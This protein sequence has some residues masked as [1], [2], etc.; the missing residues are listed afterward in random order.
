[1]P[2]MG[3]YVP[4]D[5]KT[6]HQSGGRDE[7]SLSGLTPATHASL[8]QDGG[9]D[10]ISLAALAGEPATLTTHK[11]L[12]TGIHGVGAGAIVGT[13]LAQTLTGKTLTSPTING[14]IATTGLTLPAITLGGLV[15]LNGQ[16]LDAGA[17]DAEFLTSGVQTGLRIQNTNAGDAG[18]YLIF[19]ANSAS[20]AV[21][22]DVGHIGWRGNDSAAVL[23]EYGAT[24][25]RIT[26]V[27]AG[28]RQA[29]YIWYLMDA[30]AGNMAMTLS[31]PGLGWFDVGVN[32]DE[33]YQ[34][35]GIQVIGAQGAAVADAS[36]GAN[37]DTEARAALNALLA[38]VRTHGMI[39]T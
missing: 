17:G 39:A 20:P 2:R 36:G 37:V 31:G 12:T 11:D 21:G 19:Y 4:A 34:V 14:T 25:C 6:R 38:R 26:N 1:M 32:V 7:L 10:E 27:T 23:T 5:H 30:N 24:R 28:S 35:A 13:T 8:H 33:Y 29:Q 18:T 16:T 15:T 3:G 22:D 9:A